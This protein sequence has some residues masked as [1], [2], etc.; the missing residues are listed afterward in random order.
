MELNE[1]T[2]QLLK[3]VLAGNGD[4][5]VLQVLGLDKD[6]PKNVS[7]V[8]LGNSYDVVEM[9]AQLVKTVADSLPSHVKKDFYK[10]IKKVA[11]GSKWHG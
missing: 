4:A 7:A 5:L 9:T 3:D 8:I 1:K 6:Y 11:K 10:A 2:Q